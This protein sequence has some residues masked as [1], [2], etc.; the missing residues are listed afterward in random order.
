[1]GKNAKQNTTSGEATQ[2]EVLQAEWKLLDDMLEN[3]Y[4]EL[5]TYED[6][7][8]T[9]PLTSPHI[10]GQP[11]DVMNQHDMGKVITALREHLI[12]LEQ[13]R[14]NVHT[15][16]ETLE[17]RILSQ[18]LTPDIISSIRYSMD[19]LST[20]KEN[21]G[22]LNCLYR[23]YT[24]TSVP[25]TPDRLTPGIHVF[26]KKTGYSHHGICIQDELGGIYTIGYNGDVAVGAA[27]LA[28][29][30]KCMFHHSSKESSSI[31]M[32]D[33]PSS[34]SL[35]TSQAQPPSRTHTYPP[36]L[37]KSLRASQKSLRASQKSLS[38]SQKSLSSSQKSLSS[39]QKSLRASQQTSLRS[40][41]AS[42]SS[43]TS[44]TLLAPPPSLASSSVSSSSLSA[45][46]SSSLSALP[47]SSSSSVELSSS[48]ASSSLSSLPSISEPVLSPLLV[49]SQS[50]SMPVL[51]SDSLYQQPLL[52]SVILQPPQQLQQS[53]QQQQQAL[54]VPPS[55]ALSS[56][57]N[58]P[59]ADNMQPNHRNTH[60]NPTMNF[61]NYYYNLHRGDHLENGNGDHS[62][63]F[64]TYS[65][66]YVGRACQKAKS[67]L[68]DRRKAA[69]LP[70]PTTNNTAFVQ[71]TPFQ[72]PE[73][74]KITRNPSLPYPSTAFVYTQQYQQNMLNIQ[75]FNQQ[76]QTLNK[77]F[78]TP[79]SVVHPIEH[80]KV[81]YSGSSAGYVMVTTI[82]EF[83]KGDTISIYQAH[84]KY[85]APPVVT[86]ARAKRVM[87]KGGFGWLNSNCEHLATWCMTGIGRSLQI[88][89]IFV[90]RFRKI[91]EFVENYA[92]HSSDQHKHRLTQK[93]MHIPLPLLNR[94]SE[95][96]TSQIAK[97]TVPAHYLD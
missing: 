55:L 11:S 87:L 31:L 32:A 85:C 64:A 83:T 21:Q 28:E 76:M 33:V 63:S 49:S 81:F 9:L 71:T 70:K 12:E 77:S 18:P 40:S 45:L 42:L 53:Q 46:P 74:M 20:K 48:Q 10:P 90:A 72:Q 1:M 17:K 23:I 3:I 88:E 73:L 58:H 95:I 52:Q 27:W 44:S 86:Q 84:Y 14:V 54:E 16:I 69:P 50:L 92:G 47:S 30:F 7:F 36:P 66:N 94:I 5:K 96:S 29:R 89:D 61:S 60:Q 6:E 37:Q 15:T 91:S 26:N 93:L 34:S 59:P 39:S 82:S 57:E 8:P 2:L 13:A 97:L 65:H 68:K 56:S 38:S 75:Q 62:Y 41:Q 35:P 78:K 22:H 43:Q 80:Q 51:S 25:L 4:V 79:I 67:Y 24:D 19:D